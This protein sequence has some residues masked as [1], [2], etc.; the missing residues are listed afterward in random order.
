MFKYI[1]FGL[2]ISLLCGCAV[3]PTNALQQACEFDNITFDSDFEGGRIDECYQRDDDVYELVT[4]PENQPINPS[5]WYAFRVKTD[6]NDKNITVSINAKDASPRYL[7]KISEDGENWQEIPFSV[8]D[9]ALQFSIIASKKPLYIS[10]QPLI[11]STHYEKWMNSDLVANR[12]EK[13]VIG[14]SVQGRDIHALI[15]S[16][17]DNKEWFLIIGRQHPPELTGAF[18][19][20][21]FINTL[22][23][24]NPQTNAFFDRFNILIVPFLNPDGVANGHWRHNVN[25]IDLNRDWGKFTQPETK[26]VGN[27]IEQ[28]IVPNGNIVF[29]LDFHSTQQDIFYTMPS[30]YGLAPALFSEHWMNTLRENR[31]GSFTIRERP[32]STPGRGVFKQYIADNFGVHAVTHEMGD[33]TPRYL[34]RHIAQLSATSLM[35]Q[36]LNTEKGA[37]LG[38]KIRKVTE[39]VMEQ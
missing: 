36:M 29:A 6:G 25:G 21:D 18:A 31:I 1:Y 20:M 33:N 2:V 15:H 23:E 30:D 27:Y 26:A 7:P 16:K 9:N 3:A 32:G 11:V 19:A 24:V 37:F 22:S 28:T 14:K 38:G 8:A 39:A 34:I 12:Y 35:S 4:H 10:S 5:P 13:T 17:P